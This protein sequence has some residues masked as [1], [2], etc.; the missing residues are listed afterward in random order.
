MFLGRKATFTPRA[1]SQQMKVP[2]GLFLLGLKV[3]R[4]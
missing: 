4:C 2:I 3:R 1:A